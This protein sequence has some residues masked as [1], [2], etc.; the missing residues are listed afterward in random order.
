LLRILLF[1]EETIASGRISQ[2]SK[3]EAAS[4]ASSSGSEKW[5]AR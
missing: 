2:K 4:A 3:A 1:L 5:L